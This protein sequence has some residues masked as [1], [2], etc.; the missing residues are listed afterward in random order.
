MKLKLS[1]MKVEVKEVEKIDIV[2]TIN[3]TELD[4]LLDMSYYNTSIPNQSRIEYRE[5]IKEFLDLLRNNLLR[6]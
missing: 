1:K 4:A 6:V 5:T 2:I 3:R